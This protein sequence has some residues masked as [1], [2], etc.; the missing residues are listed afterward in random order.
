MQF[1]D[2]EIVIPLIPRIDLRAA[3]VRASFSLAL[4]I[5]FSIFFLVSLITEEIRMYAY[6]ENKVIVFLAPICLLVFYGVLLWSPFNYLVVLRRKQHAPADVLR[7]NHEGI[8]FSTLIRWSE[9]KAIFPYTVT[10]RGRVHTVLGIV[11]KDYGVIV[12]RYNHEHAS[13]ILSRFLFRRISAWILR[14]PQ[15]LAPINVM[16]GVLPLSVEALM[17]EIQIHFLDKLHE[18]GIAVSQ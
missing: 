10:L 16:Q 3:I 1:A 7:I 9:I 11:P 5:G 13:G 18:H 4:L 8:Y 14:R 17:E 6:S 12:S 15:F 2:R